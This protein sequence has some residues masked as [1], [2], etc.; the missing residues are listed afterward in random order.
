MTSQPRSSWNPLPREAPPPDYAESPIPT[1][2]NQ[3]SN[4]ARPVW[5]VRPPAAYQRHRTH[6]S[7]SRQLVR[8]PERVC[9]WLCVHPRERVVGLGE[10]GTVW[11]LS[12]DWKCAQDI[13]PGAATSSR[14][15]SR[16]TEQHLPSR[17]QCGSRERALASLVR[18]AWVQKWQAISN[19]DKPIL[20]IDWTFCRED[21]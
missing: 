16:A 12:I 5:C 7:R 3:T 1:P 6:T 14:P 17:P 19:C 11:S 8:E 20:P 13:S 15:P 9:L 4:R 21:T 18:A 10:V 2:T